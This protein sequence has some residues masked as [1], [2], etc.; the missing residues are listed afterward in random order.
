[1]QFFY[2]S[3]SQKDSQYREVL[4]KSI[5]HFARLRGI[6][7]IR[8]CSASRGSHKRTLWLGEKLIAKMFSAD[9]RER[10][11]RELAFL[12]ISGD[13]E[14]T[15]QLVASSFDP[16]YGGFLVMTAVMGRLAAETQDTMS[17]GEYAAFVRS[18]GV[19]LASIHALLPEVAV[20]PVRNDLE[21]ERLSHF[22]AFPAVADRLK[23][24]GIL[25]DCAIPVLAELVAR[26]RE[27]AFAGSRGIIHGDLHI[28]NILLST[29]RGRP[30]CALIDFEESAYCRVEL[31][32]ALPLVSVLGVAFPGRRLENS[33]R[34]IWQSFVD[35]YASISNDEPNLDLLISHAVTWFLWA[36]VRGL[37]TEHARCRK[38]AGDALGAA[39]V[40]GDRYL[41][42]LAA[43][44]AIY[45][46]H[47]D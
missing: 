23:V 30:W 17:A 16:E 34:L 9:A 14:R 25:E 20:Y 3:P 10:Y 40:S 7:T 11:E 46:D 33:W 8:E 29:Q 5:E 36:S 18:L 38:F 19:S 43:D 12:R 39:A 37:E 2:L 28:S 27:L 26:G 32:L 6:T 22:D 1:M 44:A 45:A 47:A 42:R 21:H 35:G 4:R 13:G 31:D 24:A 41:V 15:P